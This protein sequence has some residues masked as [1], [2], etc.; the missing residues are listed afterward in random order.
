[1]GFFRLE[2]WR[3]LPFP[4][5]GDLLNRGTELTSPMFPALQ[6]D[7]LLTEPVVQFSHSVV[8]DSLRPHGLQHARL[9]CPLSTP[10]VYSNSCPLS[11]YASQPS[12]PLSSSSPPA[13]NLSQHQGLFKCGQLFAS[14]SL[15]IGVSASAE[16]E[17]VL[18]M[19]IQG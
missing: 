7:S 15:S 3:G 1:M 16:T 11:Q 12:H 17:T 2:Y 18:P 13:F 9:P 14:G 5:P 10:G 8:S 4:P 19:N 6:A